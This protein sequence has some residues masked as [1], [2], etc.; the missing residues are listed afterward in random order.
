M[1]QGGTI[2][3]ALCWVKRGFA[4]AELEEYFPTEEEIQEGKKLS[5]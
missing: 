4:K 3:S 1:E 2:I 5:K